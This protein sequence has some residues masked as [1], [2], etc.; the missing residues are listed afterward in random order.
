MTLRTILKTKGYSSKN[1]IGEGSS[2]VV[3]KLDDYAVMNATDEQ[4]GLKENPLEDDIIKSNRRYEMEYNFTLFLHQTLTDESDVVYIPKVFLYSG[5]PFEDNRFRYAKEVCD[6]I[7]IEDSLF[8]EMIQVSDKLLDNGWFYADMKPENLGRFD[9]KLSILDTDYRSFYR[10]PDKKKEDFRLWSYLII[11]VY[12][13]NFVEMNKE[14]LFQFIE[15]KKLTEEKCETL[16]QRYIGD[17]YLNIM[18]QKRDK[19]TLIA[20]DIS[21]EIVEYGNE[22]FIEKKMDKYIQLVNIICPYEFFIQYGYKG[23]KTAHDIFLELITKREI[24]ENS[25]QSNVKPPGRRSVKVNQN[26]LS[27][28]GTTLSTV[29]PRTSAILRRTAKNNKSLVSASRPVVRTM[30]GRLPPTPIEVRRSLPVRLPPPP[31][32]VRRSLSRVPLP[33]SRTSS[34]GVKK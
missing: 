4:R 19:R 17:D 3:W 14:R 22:Y 1:Y 15:D 9:G 29:R 13:Y 30:T 5:D 25:R 21:I 33:P 23:D 31:G 2:K 28:R 26:R 7:V 18:N 11:L 6:K 20:E 10:V 24:V 27:R 16:F 12:C 8:E 34:I 32:E